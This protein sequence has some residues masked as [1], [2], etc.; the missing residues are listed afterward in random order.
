[1]AKIENIGGIESVVDPYSNECAVWGCENIA[2]EVNFNKWRKD[3]PGCTP[4]ALCQEH[5]DS[6]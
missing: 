5:Y 4:V 1:M 6:Y 3:H 2:I